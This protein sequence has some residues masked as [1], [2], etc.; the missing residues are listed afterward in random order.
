MRQEV[1]KLKNINNCIKNIIDE[2][3]LKLTKIASE[4]GIGYQRLNRLFNQNTRMLASEFISLCSFLQIDPKIFSD[5][6]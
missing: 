4:T 3:G 5:A 2:K 6:A 1:K